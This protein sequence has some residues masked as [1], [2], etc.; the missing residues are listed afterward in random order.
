MTK[1]I[2][3]VILT[4]RKEER[5][6]IM[7]KGIQCEMCKFTI[8]FELKESVGCKN[9][10]QIEQLRQERNI[11]FTILLIILVIATGGIISTTYYVVDYIMYSKER[12]VS[13]FFSIVLGADVL[14]LL[15]LIVGLLV[16]VTEFLLHKS[17]AIENISRMKNPSVLKKRLENN[18]K[19]ISINE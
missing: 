8:M 4:K 6:R 11:L 7:E 13:F 16:F 1:W 12:E 2:I 10:Q 9:R 17:L 19:T 14:L 18:R 15:I 3:S 5:K